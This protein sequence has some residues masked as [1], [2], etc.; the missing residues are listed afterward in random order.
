MLVSLRV[1]SRALVEVES[2]N[3]AELRFSS[4]QAYLY[5]AS[6]QYISASVGAQNAFLA[7]VI[8]CSLKRVAWMSTAPIRTAF[9]FRT[10]FLSLK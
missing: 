8:P 9:I 5:L 4:I 7:M 1:L 6:L 10:L 3:K 2:L